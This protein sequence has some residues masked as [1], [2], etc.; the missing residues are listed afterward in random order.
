MTTDRRSLRLDPS[1]IELID[2]SKGIE[3]E[4]NGRPVHAYEGDTVGSALYASGVRIFSRSFKYHRVRGMLCVSGN[5]PNC[6]MTVDG[7]PNV[8]ACVQRVE[9]GMK[10][11][12]QN[13]WPGLERDLFSVIDRF[14]W[15][16]PVGFYYK[17]LY[18]P[19]ALWNFSASLIRRIRRTGKRQSRCRGA[20]IRASLVCPRRRCRRGGR[21][22]GDVR[23]P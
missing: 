14:R 15:A 6:L 1:P 20:S 11:K 3:F 2:R 12:G 17:G 23:S 22:R 19:R 9:Q 10:V 8:R 13:A 4:F 18:R 21:Y 16:L 7:V 5:C